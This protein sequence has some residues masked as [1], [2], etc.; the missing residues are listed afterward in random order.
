MAI[1]AHIELH[2]FENHVNAATLLE[3]DGEALLS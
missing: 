2:G 1:L 3:F